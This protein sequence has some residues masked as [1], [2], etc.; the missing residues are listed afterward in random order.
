[1]Y[2]KNTCWNSIFSLNLGRL[3]ASGRCL[4]LFSV[5]RMKSTL[6]SDAIPFCIVYDA[7]EISFTGFMML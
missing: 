4:M 1:M 5:L 2:L 3:I 7:L 6:S